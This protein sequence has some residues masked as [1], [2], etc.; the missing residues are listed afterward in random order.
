MRKHEILKD[1]GLYIDWIESL[2]TLTEQQVNTPYQEGKWSPKEIVMH[3]AEWD[4]FT[5]EQRLPNMKESE[6]LEDVP[7][8][9]FN[10]QAAKLANDY[11]FEE[12]L[13]LAKGYRRQLLERLEAI[14]E[15]EWTK[16][17]YI[18]EHVLTL[19]EYFSDFV[20]HDTHHKEQIESI[21]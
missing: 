18:G 5:L 19:E 1:F 13:E 14:D 15:A 17:F 12:I 7:W 4:R 21:R 16:S 8:E 10:E 2:R 6:K 9:S 11:T 20:W 3:M